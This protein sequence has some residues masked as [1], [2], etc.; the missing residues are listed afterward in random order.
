VR[1]DAKVDAMRQVPLFSGCSKRELG[2]IAAIADELQFPPG[3]DLMKEGSPGRE[4][5]IVLDGV[6]E[7]RKNGRKMPIRGGTVFFGE[8]ALLSNSPRTA[9]VTTKT[10][11]RALVITDRAFRR[12]LDS[13]PQIQHKVLA[14]LAERLASDEL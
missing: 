4:F 5:V 2:E 12:I 9:T 3:R 1:K 13:S 10:P 7:V 8:I 6:V 11:V 14:S